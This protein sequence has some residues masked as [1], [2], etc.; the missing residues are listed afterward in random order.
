MADYLEVSER[1][2]DMADCLV[3][4]EKKNALCIQSILH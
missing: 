1:E 3:I 2:K 4:S